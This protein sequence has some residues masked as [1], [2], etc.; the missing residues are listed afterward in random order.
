MGECPNCGLVGMCDCAEQGRGIE[1]TVADLCE[2]RGLALNASEEQLRKTHAHVVELEAGLVVMAL[3]VDT[4]KARATHAEKGR[5]AAT[6]RAET[7]EASLE[8]RD[9]QLAACGV[10]AQGWA[11]G[12]NDCSA[13]DYGWSASFG[14]VKALRRKQDAAA[15]KL[16][17]ARAAGR[18]LANYWRVQC[19]GE[20]GVTELLRAAWVVEKAALVRA[21][22]AAQ[23]RTAEVIADWLDDF[24][25]GDAMYETT[26]TLA[27]E[28]RRKWGR[29]AGTEGVSDG[30]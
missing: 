7:A 20:E 29:P 12:E 28:I 9:V 14:D 23:R 24:N 25:I 5:D 27:A 19:Q 15:A 1:T 22:E 2:R 16:A 17:I 6:K 4:H 3:E 30:D 13:G 10:A 18:R 21:V 11:T 26:G 8:Q